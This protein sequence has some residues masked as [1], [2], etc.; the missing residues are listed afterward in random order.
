MAWTGAV[1]PA[2]VGVK[3]PIPRKINWDAAKQRALSGKTARFSNYTYPTY[4]W[5]VDIG[6]LR[7]AQAFTELQQL[8]G[9]V[10]ALQGPVGLFGYTDPDDNA[11]SNATFGLGDGATAGPFQ[12]VRPFGNFVEPIFLLN[13]NP[14][15]SVAGTPTTAFTVDLYG[16]VT[17]NAAPANGAQL[18]WSGAFYWPCRFD[19]DST[20]ISLFQSGIYQAKKLAFSSEKLP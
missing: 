4:S 17:F 2:L 13:G 20:D 6:V 1:F 14:T 10:N 19:D 9:F 5:Q 7:S 8:M 15:I 11:V 18:T 16:R 12:L 3:F